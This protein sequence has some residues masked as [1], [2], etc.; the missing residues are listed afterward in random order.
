ME[1]DSQEGVPLVREIK[2][3]SSELKKIKG[4]ALCNIPGSRGQ[5]A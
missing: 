3:Q 5:L 4:R 1:H 2:Q